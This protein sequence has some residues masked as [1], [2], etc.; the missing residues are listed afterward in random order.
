VDHGKKKISCPVQVLWGAK[1]AV[2]AWYDVRD[3][4]RS[5]TGDLRGEAIDC[6]HFIP[7]EKPAETIRA[8]R[9]FFVEGL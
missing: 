8:M 3:V 5:W 7:E 6:G 2:G 9:R 4:W 1:G